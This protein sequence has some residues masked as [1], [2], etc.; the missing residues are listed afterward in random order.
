MIAWFLL[1]LTAAPMPLVQPFPTREACEAVADTKPD[2][3]CFPAR[4]PA[5]RPITLEDVR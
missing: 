1:A 3:Q 5:L 4:V 2:A